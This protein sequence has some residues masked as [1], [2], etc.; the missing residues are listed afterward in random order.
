ML[1]Y[2]GLY[3]FCAPPYDELDRGQT[4]IRFYA[5][6]TVLVSGNSGTPEQAI[7]V[8]N[9]DAKYVSKGRYTVADNQLV[10]SAS[11]AITLGREH[12][13]DGNMVSESIQELMVVHYEGIIDGETLKMHVTAYS[14][15][16]GNILTQNF[17]DQA[18]TFVKVG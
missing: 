8:I 7:R 12:M 9:K 16:E 1:R 2:D 10:F 11:V 5:D 17:G 3:R 6:G 15:R 13:Q 18:Y 14:H 4:Y